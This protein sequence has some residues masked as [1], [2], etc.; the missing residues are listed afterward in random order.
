MGLLQMGLF[1]AKYLK[2]LDLLQIHLP[3]LKQD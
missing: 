1:Q 2:Q 3:G